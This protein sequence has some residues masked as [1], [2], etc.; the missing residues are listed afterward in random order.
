VKACDLLYNPITLFFVEED[1]GE[2]R[3]IDD[4]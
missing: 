1:C 3:L 2:G 4:R